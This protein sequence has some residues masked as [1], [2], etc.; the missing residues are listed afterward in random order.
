MRLQVPAQDFSLKETIESGQ[1]F[2][3]KPHPTDGSFYGYIG[4]TAMKVR[5]EDAV[6]LVDTADE[7]LTPER[8]AHYFALDQDLPK[9][10]AAI[11]VDPYIHEAIVRYHGLRIVRQDS[12]ECLASFILSSFNNIVRI[13]GMIE[14]LCTA[15]GEPAAFNGFRG[16]TFPEPQ[17]LAMVPE[18]RLR[19][20]GLGYR[21]AYLRST[22]RMIASGKFSLSMLAQADYATTKLALQHCDGVGE[23]VADCV[24]LFGLQKYEAFPVD[25]WIGRAMRHYF[26]GKKMTPARIRVFAAEHFGPWAGYA[27]QY[28]FHHLRNYRRARPTAETVEGGRPAD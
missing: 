16:C 25:V 8:V 13:Q 10:L 7:R 12:W 4:N 27:Q 3:W 14:R 9:I 18:K 15:F 26:R 24:A 28:L 17:R 6:L 20:L 21:A 2:R 11:D 22:A 5:Q 23:K 19:E 1:V